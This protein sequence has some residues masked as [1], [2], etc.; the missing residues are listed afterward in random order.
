MC[1]L[2]RTETN[3]PPAA[4]CAQGYVRLCFDLGRLVSDWRVHWKRVFDCIRSLSISITADAT[5]ASHLPLVRA[6]VSLERG[7]KHGMTSR[8]QDIVWICLTNNHA[9]HAH[10]NLL[11]QD[12]YECLAQCQRQGTNV[13]V[14]GVFYGG[15]LAGGTPRS[16]QNKLY[17]CDST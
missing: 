8:H 4:G 17:H 16:V 1:R 15:L 11:C 9:V 3:P 6:M 10:R 14:A 2:R 5:V 7:Y 12:G 13:H